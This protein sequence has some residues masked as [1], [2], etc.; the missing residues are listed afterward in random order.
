MLFFIWI[1]DLTAVRLPENRFSIMN[2]TIKQIEAFFSKYKVC[3][4]A[5][6]SRSKLAYCLGKYCLNKYITRLD[7]A[8]VKLFSS[9][10]KRVRIIAIATK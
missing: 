3:T 2:F 9:S 6:D 5:I 4:Y 8:F 10:W 7:C 1:S